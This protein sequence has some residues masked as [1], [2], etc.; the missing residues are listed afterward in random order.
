MH[1]FFLHILILCSLHS[2]FGQ[3]EVQPKRFS[4][5]FGGGSYFIDN[6][7]SMKLK[8]FLRQFESFDEYN[9][10]IHSH[11]DNIGGKEYN[12]WLSQMRSNAALQ[13]LIFNDVPEVIISIQDFGSFNPVYD[14]STWMGRL[15]N[16]R[17]DIIFWPIVL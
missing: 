9:V 16:R 4:I 1:R 2:L 5:Y 17:V 8:D 7:Q 14:N 12:Q 6:E 10:S 15:K 11:T 13:E 3:G